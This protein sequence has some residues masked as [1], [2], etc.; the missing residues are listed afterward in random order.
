MYQPNLERIAH[1]IINDSLAVQ[2]G[3]HGIAEVRS[4][5]ATYAL[6]LAREAHKAGSTITLLLTSDEVVYREIMETPLPYLSLPQ[7]PQLAAT[8]AADYYVSI[9]LSHAEPQRFYALPPDRMAA[10]QARRRAHH[11]VL[12]DESEARWIGTDFPTRS[13][14]TDA[15]VSWETLY[16]SYWRAMDIDYGRLRE[17]AAALAERLAQAQQFTLTAPNGTHLRFTRGERR[18]IR[19]DGRVREVGNLPAGEVVFAPIEE[20]VEG[21][22]IFDFGHVGGR[23]LAALRARVEGGHLTPLAAEQGYEPFLEYWQRFQG[24]EGR[25][26]EVGI[27]LNPEVRVPVGLDG[28]DQKANGLLHLA[29]GNNEILGGANSTALRLV[30]YIRQARLTAD[31]SLVLDKG[32]FPAW[33]P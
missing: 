30:L 4:D 22:V 7:L 1:K 28:V 19:D 12:Y 21:E 29:L 20:S 6:L 23:P 27:G 13:M 33:M 14:M 24:S 2:P 32:H 17:R 15:G 3:E 26:G 18:V 11:A 9:G 5:A 10:Y 16:E 25:L 8:R 31:E